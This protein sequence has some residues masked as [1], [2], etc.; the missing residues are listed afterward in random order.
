MSTFGGI[1]FGS[2]SSGVTSGG[3]LCQLLALGAIDAALTLNPEVT[4]WRAKIQKCTNFAME[5]ITQ[6]FNG[7][8]TWGSDAQVTLNK[9][10]DLV[11]WIYILIDIPG[12]KA[13]ACNRSSSNGFDTQR[14]QR[15]P[16]AKVCDACDDGRR[17]KNC[18]NSS[19]DY[20]S[21]SSSSS[22]YDSTSNSASS[23][24]SSS[25]VGS[26][27]SGSFDSN[28]SD[29]SCGCDERADEFG[30]RRPFCNWV[31]AIG[32]AA[33]HRVA[34]SIGGQVIDTLFCH[35]LNMW[36]ELA[37]QPGK[38]LE[39]MIGH[40]PFPNRAELVAASQK[41]RRLYVPIP[42]EF[43]RHSGNA[44]PLV[45]IQFHSLCLHVTF[46]PLHKLIQ[47]SDCDVVVVKTCDGHPITDNDMR[48]MVDTTY[49][50]LDQEERDRFA[51]G[52]FTQLIPTV[53]HYQMTGNCSA[54]LTAN[55]NFNHACIEMFWAVQRQCQVVA[56]NT[57]DY[58]GAWGRDPITRAK[59][60]VNN[61][62]RFDREAEYF[63]LVQPYQHHTN[64]PRSFIYNYSFSIHPEDCQPG[65]SL[66]WSKIDNIEFSVCLQDAIAS[67]QVNM[68][69][70]SRVWNLVKYKLG[71]GGVIF[72]N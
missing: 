20:S 55:L 57:F 37:G 59:L 35:Y 28:D 16:Y 47:V 2:L 23:F 15:F 33:L 66:N 65:A 53:Q 72:A 1:G 52:C 7:T 51:V 70:F 14:L 61:L 29:S 13:A 27:S 25:S 71:L 5:S 40:C 62:T 56:N 21:R 9:T 10:G 45:S 4:Y 22:S 19:S 12:I 63:R 42:F 18:S 58:S 8:C 44:L 38:R 24:G 43:A 32:F 49:V 48:A 31:D 6:T 67:T 46:N 26:S 60:L 69:L 50:Y 64:I 34:Y 11:Y 3:T 39:E 68:Y 41:N 36:E 30:L 17:K 54:T